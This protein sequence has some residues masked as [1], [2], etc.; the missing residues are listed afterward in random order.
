MTSA[1]ST[2]R[3]TPALEPSA[4]SQPPVVRRR[5]SEQKRALVRH[6]RQATAFIVLLGL[7]ILAVRALRPQPVAV[8]QAVLRSGPLQVAVQESGMTRV[9]DRFEVSAPVTGTLSRIA[10]DPGDCVREGDVLAEIAPAESPLLDERARAQ[11][12]AKLEAA[13]AALGQSRALVARATSARALADREL[14]RTRALVRAN[15]ASQ[16]ALDQIEFE[17]RMRQDEVASAEFAAKIAGEE[18][19]SARAM[20]GHNAIL[21]HNDAPASRARH[22]GVL[23]P[24]SGNVLRVYH[25]SAGVVQAGTP[26]LEVGDPEALEV[27]VDLL[28]TDAVQVSSGTPVVI[29]GW[30]R[31]RTLQGRVRRIEP[32][33]FTRPSALGVDEQRVNVVIAITEPPEHWPELADSFR[34]EVRIVLWEAK[35]VLKAPH[36]AV[37]RHGDGWAAYRIEGD[38]V[39][40]TPVSIG[41]RGDTEV[42]VLSGLTEGTLVAVHP[43]DRVK[44]GVRVHV[45]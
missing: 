43:G 18:V 44:D 8:D 28:T 41:H 38:R 35:Q 30:G 10:L 36:G 16:Q 29:T 7:A 37:F 22:V 14:E 33:G 45:R 19:R 3:V 42:E 21:G 17:A 2:D 40:L 27:V 15:T 34:V 39:H 32:S 11:A 23:A 13:L 5:R 6:A 26:L 20:L 9:K 31:D 12:E 4:G 25:E 1:E 24:V